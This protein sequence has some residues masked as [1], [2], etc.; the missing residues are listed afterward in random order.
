MRG[1]RTY[2]AGKKALIVYT[3]LNLLDKGLVFLTPFFVLSLFRA[4][5]DY[6][7][8]EYV[9]STVNI[10]ATLTDLG[11]SGYMFY[12]Y[13]RL[14]DKDRAVRIAKSVSGFI[15]LSL[16]GLS[17]LL[18]LI[19]T[20]VAEIHVLLWFIMARLLYTY[21]TVYFT[22]Y[23]RLVDRP[24][25]AVYISLAVN[26]LTL[27]LLG[28]FY[29]SGR[30]FSLWLI[31]VP[32][33][34]LV[35]VCTVQLFLSRDVFSFSFVTVRRTLMSSLKF[36]WPSM[37][38]VF[39]MM[40]MANYG[41][42]NALD[43]LSNDEA[44]FLG[45]TL[46]FCMIMQLAHASLAGFYAKTILAGDDRFFIS[47]KLLFLYAGVLATAC[48]LVTAGLLAYMGWFSRGTLPSGYALLVVLFSVYT[49]AWCLYSYLEMYYARIGKNSIKL[50]LTF[51]ILTVFI[52]SLRIPGLNLL[53][54]I[55]FAM[56]FSIIAGLTANIIVLRKLKF[57]LG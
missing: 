10:F 38:Q 31:L 24:A 41:R 57:R 43:R 44:V 39:L 17:L 16:L 52:L 12:L 46:R 35:L 34:L 22:A 26:V 55:A 14:S 47:R 18:L 19:H 13:Q 49:L 7:E 25:L 37:V 5:S 48:V 36:S 54:S 32:Q 40:Y 28:G 51:L 6:V 27:L 30:P 11:M 2:I 29:L 21:L 20:Y 50:Y 56:F 15:F 8:L 45:F 23:F 1:V 9:I 4:A 3:G 42:I 53:Y 33:A